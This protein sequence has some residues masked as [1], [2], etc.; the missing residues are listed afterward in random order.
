MKRI[1]EYIAIITLLLS[2]AIGVSAQEKEKKAQVSGRVTDRNGEPLA[3]IRVSA[4]RAG[5]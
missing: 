5:R 3:G 1:I 4:G 2:G